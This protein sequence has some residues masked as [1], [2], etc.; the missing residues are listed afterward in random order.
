MRLGAPE[1]LE[2]VKIEK[3]KVKVTH[4]CLTLCNP[5]V[6]SPPWSSVHGT[7]LARVLEWVPLPSP[8]RTL[9][10][11]IKRYPTPKDKEA[12]TVRR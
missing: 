12:A 4:L 9:E 11:T 10:P 1:C 6:C 7:F 3:M 5:L 2:N 8:R